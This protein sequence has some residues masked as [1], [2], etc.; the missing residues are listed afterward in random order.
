MRARLLFDNGSGVGKPRSGEQK[1]GPRK[2]PRYLGRY[3]GLLRL[4][5]TSRSW[6]HNKHTL[7]TSIYSAFFSSFLFFSLRNEKQRR[8]CRIS[9]RLYYTALL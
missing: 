4:C 3:L 5:R 1:G 8:V 7:S 9:L 2:L 6:H